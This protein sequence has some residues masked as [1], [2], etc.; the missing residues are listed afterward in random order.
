MNTTSMSRSSL[1]RIAILATTAAL[2]SASAP[3]ADSTTGARRPVAIS[4]ASATAPDV[5]DRLDLPTAIK[6]ALENNFAIRQARERIREQ[7]GLIVEIKSRALPNASVNSIYGLTDRELNSDSQAPG[8]GTRD[9]EYW[10]IALEVRQ[11]LYSGGGVKN[12]LDA[13]KL[14]RESALLELEAVINTALLDVR[15][16]FYNVLLAREQTKVQEENVRLLREQLQTAKNRFEAGASSNFDVLRAEVAVA[17][18]QPGLIRARNGYRIAIDELRQSLGYANTRTDSV[19]KT[20]EFVGTL[21]FTPVNYD[22]PTAITDARNNRPELKRLE[23]L[24]LAREAAVKVAKSDYQ[25]D[26]AVVGGYEL[27]KNNFSNKFSN[28][29]DG[30]TIGLQSNWAIFDGRATAGRVAQARSQLNQSR[31]LTS[32]STLAVEVEV[33]RAHSSLQE[34]AELAES[35]T[36]VVAQAEEALRL[37]DAR[38]AAGTATQLDVLE[39]RVALTDS[40]NNQLQA[41]YSYNVAVAAMRKAIGSADPFVVKP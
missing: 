31:L 39:A 24:E 19:R 32:E 15:T 40:R 16:R 33:R 28:S 21:D 4:A 1:A 29:L 12:A 8:A 30:W 14:A 37:A 9:T 3:A 20:P 27:R 6:Y 41:N 35:A 5:P 23:K 2:T 38:Y 13:Q 11:V 10:S 36:K 34:A 22:L 18:A 25:P 7:E 17:N 26:L